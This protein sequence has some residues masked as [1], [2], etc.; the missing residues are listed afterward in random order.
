MSLTNAG[1]RHL[2]SI[3]ELFAVGNENPGVM[4]VDEWTDSMYYAV[5]TMGGSP[6]VVVGRTSGFRLERKGTLTSG[7]WRRDRPLS[8]PDRELRSDWV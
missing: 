8:H 5:T 2:A 6:G 3:A 7:G 4:T 1:G